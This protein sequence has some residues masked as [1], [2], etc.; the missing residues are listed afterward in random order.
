MGLSSMARCLYVT[1]GS[2]GTCETLAE[3]DASFVYSNSGD[4]ISVVFWLAVKKATLDYLTL[5][6]SPT[7]RF[8]RSYRR[9]NFGSLVVGWLKMRSTTSIHWH[10]G[11][12]LQPQV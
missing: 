11:E 10:N 6:D 2:R 8:S 9:F 4:M 1:Q 12:K 7:A 5:A 3:L